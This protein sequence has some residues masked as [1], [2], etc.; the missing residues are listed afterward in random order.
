VLFIRRA[1]DPG[2]GKL[3][4]PGGFIDKLE[5]AED[6]VRREIQEELGLEL[7]SLRYLVSA[8]NLYTYKDVPYTVLDLHFRARVRSFDVVLQAEEVHGY[9]RLAPA[10][11]PLDDLAFESHR[12]ALRALGS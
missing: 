8:P 2:R 11:V 9:E 3:A 5:T 7:V 1:K 4:L 10:D 12:V 6:A